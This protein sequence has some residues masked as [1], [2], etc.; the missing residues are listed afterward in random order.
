MLS[1]SYFLIVVVHT[2]KA[3]PHGPMYRPIHN[4]P[5]CT[6]QCL[7][8]HVS[9]LSLNTLGMS[10]EDLLTG[11]LDETPSSLQ[12]DANS[13]FDDWFD[14]DATASGKKAAETKGV[15]VENAT[16]TSERV[17]PA[18]AG[19]DK[20][21]IL[22]SSRPMV[23]AKG[24]S[25]PE[26][27]NDGVSNYKSGADASQYDHDN[28]ENLSGN[29]TSTH[30]NRGMAYRPEYYEEDDG[31]SYDHYELV[32]AGGKPYGPVSM[33][34]SQDDL[35]SGVVIDVMEKS[36]FLEKTR[37]SS[38]D[39]RMSFD[40][41]M[42]DEETSRR[43]RWCLV[44]LKSYCV[45]FIITIISVSAYLA[46]DHSSTTEVGHSVTNKGTESGY[47]ELRL[48]NRRVFYRIANTVG[49]ANH[50]VLL[51]H[52]D[53]QNGGCLLY[54]MF[55]CT[56]SWQGNIKTLIIIKL[57]FPAHLKSYTS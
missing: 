44:C 35:D 31:L 45:I 52:G 1:I 27:G 7:Y 37:T 9:F 11:I 21:I 10:K 2:N 41:G 19:L 8:F 39:D 22:S 49:M 55:W 42:T 38:S 40:I 20:E 57:Q 32:Q 28:S 18:N 53:S 6:S 12:F 26:F 46:V 16:A 23:Q 50:S 33:F 13:Y 5:T 56:P 14:D 51:V 25:L 54:D 43:A 4:S 29:A 24:N 17:E 48:G 3:T 34:D 36:P 15:A 30:T 47:K